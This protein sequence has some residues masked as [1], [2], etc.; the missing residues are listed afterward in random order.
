M[1]RAPKHLAMQIWQ[2]AGGRCEY[3]RLPQEFC[4]QQ[5]EVEHIIPLKHGGVTRLD[6]LA[7]A[8]LVCNRRKG[9]NLSGMHPETKVMTRLFNPRMDL[10]HDHFAWDGPIMPG[11][12]DIGN[13]TISVLGTNRALQVELRAD[14]INAGQW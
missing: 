12:S 10:W 1:P 4:N 14:L 7:W 13:V 9:T 6:N 5:F 2:R 11:R 8:C 3:C